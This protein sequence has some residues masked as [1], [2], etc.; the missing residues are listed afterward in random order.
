MR[1]MNSEDGKGVLITAVPLSSHV[2]CSLT[3]EQVA[4]MC[5][6]CLRALV[7]L[8]SKG[9][10]HRDIKSDSI[11]L[12]KDGKVCHSDV[13]EQ[14]M[15]SLHHCD[16]NST[17]SLHHCDVMDM[18]V[19]YPSPSFPLFSLSLPSTFPPPPPSLPFPISSL[20]PPPPFLFPLPLSLYPPSPSPFPP[21]PSFTQVKLSDFGFCARVTTDHPHRKSLVGTPYWMAPEVIARQQYSTEVSIYCHTH[22]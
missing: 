1:V 20:S 15:H 18:I 4:A 5:K 8:H 3:E 7:Y 16:V 13:I 21:P 10:V 9:V 2:T 11:L 14:H 22:L 17:W 12:M 19:F 6:S